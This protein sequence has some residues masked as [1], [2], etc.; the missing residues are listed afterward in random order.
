MKLTSI[1]L[2]VSIANR[3]F[4]VIKQNANSIDTKIIRTHLSENINNMQYSE[5]VNL[6]PLASSLVE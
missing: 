1:R 2:Y 4:K 6:L 5:M 3:M